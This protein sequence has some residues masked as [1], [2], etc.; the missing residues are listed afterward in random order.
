[1][2]EIKKLPDGTEFK[3]KGLSIEIGVSPN[4]DNDFNDCYSIELTRQQLISMLI[5]MDEKE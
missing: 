4:F 3:I 2:N 1:M 5:A